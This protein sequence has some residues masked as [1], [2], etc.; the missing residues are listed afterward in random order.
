MKTAKSRRFY[1]NLLGVLCV[2]AVHL[3][4]II[5]VKRDFIVFISDARLD[6][7]RHARHQQIK[8]LIGYEAICGDRQ[9]QCDNAI[10]RF[11][12]LTAF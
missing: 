8:C 11:Q 7:I 3:I 5:I 1:M 10:L 2:L 12:T 9:G 4:C 6:G